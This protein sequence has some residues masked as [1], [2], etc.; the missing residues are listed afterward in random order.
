VPFSY[1]ERLTLFAT[2]YI[3]VIFIA[4]TREVSPLFWGGA[5]VSLAVGAYFQ[6]NRQRLLQ[7]AVTF[8]TVLIVA[9]G[10]VDLFY[11]AANYL[12]AIVD[13]VLLLLCLKALSSYRVAD[14]LQMMGLSF[15]LV[16]AAAVITADAMFGILFLGYIFSG[17]SALVLQNLRGHWE[18]S[19]GDT[20]ILGR[21]RGVL[22]RAF[23]VAIVAL[24]F[25]ILVFTLVLYFAFPRV[26][27]RIWKA[28]I[29]PRNRVAGFSDSVRLND[30]GRIQTNPAIAFRVEYPD[31]G[32]IP[33]EDSGL[34]RFRGVV[35]ENFD[36][37]VWK[38]SSGKVEPAQRSGRMEWSAQG[39]RPEATLL[40]SPEPNYSSVLFAPRGTVSIKGPFASV[41]LLPSG[42]WVAERANWSR[43]SYEIGVAEVAPDQSLPTEAHTSVP[44]NATPRMRSLLEEW[45]GGLGGVALAE[46]LTLRLAS[47]LSYTTELAD[48]TVDSPLDRFLFETRKGHCELFAASL[49]VL[50]RMEGIPTR[51]VNGFQGGDEWDS[52]SVVFRDLHAHSWVEAYFPGK[53]WVEFDPTPPTTDELS[54]QQEALRQYFDTLTRARL[55]WGRWFVDYDFGDQ[56]EFA[57]NFQLASNRIG[58]QLEK[59][60]GIERAREIFR[61]N[62]AI[63]GAT[64]L[65]V[66]FLAFALRRRGGKVSQNR[67]TR[68]YR[69][70]LKMA[71]RAR[72]RV[73]GETPLQFALQLSLHDRRW[74]GFRHYTELYYKLRYGDGSADDAVRFLELHDAIPKR[75]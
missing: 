74:E 12:I 56:R 53:G 47:E 16:L 41:G 32:G 10:V 46:R 73:K 42:D 68:L 57:K 14:N 28:D 37:Y 6:A 71:E 19:G 27:F 48:D 75:E 13:L 36:G 4:F 8:L 51:L 66:L 70:R 39:K 49:A 15:L 31:D 1:Y 25:G 29:G 21:R 60:T 67:L 9:F 69:K 33:G 43:L 5:L 64:V 59:G 7:S 34:R 11:I 62:R 44:E 54:W 23:A 65:A 52:N 24:C 50:L 35:L 72:P 61:E 20:E 58:T 26:G 3:S 40:V 38:E 2:L 63:V 30:V 17:L 22:G 55:F 45:G 18:N